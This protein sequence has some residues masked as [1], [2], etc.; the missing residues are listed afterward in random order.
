VSARRRHAP[1][2]G[3]GHPPTE[4]LER[5]PNRQLAAPP[6]PAQ[7]ASV[8]NVGQDAPYGYSPDTRRVSQR[9]KLRPVELA[10]QARDPALRLNRGDSRDR[11]RLR[12]GSPK[13]KADRER[14]KRSRKAERRRKG[15][16]ERTRG[17]EE[18]QHRGPIKHLRQPR[19]PALPIKAETHNRS[20]PSP[21][22]N[23]P[24]NPTTLH[25]RPYMLTVPPLPPPRPITKNIT[26]GLR[27]TRSIWQV[28]EGGSGAKQR[29]PLPR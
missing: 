17:Q 26:P 12:R 29:T 7:L 11:R 5:P 13:R 19:F 25:L 4:P 8:Q 15:Q 20:T 2:R 3:T 6:E 27:E 9:S 24:K 14:S 16:K 10:G 18:E 23:K 1:D 22:T 28:E 21:P